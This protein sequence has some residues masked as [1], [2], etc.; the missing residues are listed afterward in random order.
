MGETT[1]GSGARVRSR[2][3]CPR[4]R[5]A[6]VTASHLTTDRYGG[7]LVDLDLVATLRS[8]GAA[9]QFLPDGAR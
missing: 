7:Q 4:G 2:R 3:L 6:P 9:R 5:W 1:S 8:T